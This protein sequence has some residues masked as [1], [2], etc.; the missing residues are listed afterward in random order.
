MMNDN[1]TNQ[2]NQ[3]IK[4]HEE[5]HKMYNIVNNDL[6]NLPI[7]MEE[8]EAMQALE[9]AM[10][11]TAKPE[12]PALPMQDYALMASLISTFTKHIETLVD[13]RFAALVESHK[14]LKLMDEEMQLAIANLIDDRIHE[15]ESDKDHFD[16]GEIEYHVDHQIRNSSEIVSEKRVEEIVSDA[17]DEILE[18]RV[19]DLLSNASVEISV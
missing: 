4:Q 19:R 7:T 10:Q 1:Q 16:E 11:E 2:A 13:Q 3:Y 9:K 12:A 18:D 14:T 5:F 8:D 6:N 17:L 15:H